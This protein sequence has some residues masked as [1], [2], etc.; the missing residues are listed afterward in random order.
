VGDLAVLVPVR[1]RPHRVQPLLDSVK[2]TVPDARVVF[3]ADP[4][5]EPE[6]R[7]IRAAGL[8]GYYCVKGNYA[9]KINTAVGLTAEPFLFLGADDLEF[10]PGWYE[11]ARRKMSNRIHVVGVNDLLHRRRPDHATH[12]LVT[13]EYASLPTIDGQPGPLH[14]GYGH[15]FC[16]DELIGTARARFTYAYCPGARVRHLHP[17]NQSAPDDDTYR[18]GRSRFRRDSKLFKK[19]RLLWR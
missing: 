7:A 11:A 14:A 1:G 9:D 10:Q 15:N 8:T 5:D 2:A 3:I 4:D 16:D 6:I 18:L 17:M 19:R 12:F 13:R